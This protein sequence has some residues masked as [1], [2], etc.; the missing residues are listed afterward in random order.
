VIA[1]GR[2][3][4]VFTAAVLKET[5]SGEMVVFQHDGMVMIGERPHALH[6]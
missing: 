3:S 2:P 6:E 1:E 4:E 5:Y